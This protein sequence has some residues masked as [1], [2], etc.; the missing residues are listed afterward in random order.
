MA[1]GDHYQ[2]YKDRLYNGGFDRMG[3][4]QKDADEI[5]HYLDSGE[6]FMTDEFVNNVSDKI[7]RPLKKGSAYFYGEHF[8]YPGRIYLARDEYEDPMTYGIYGVNPRRHNKEYYQAAL[9]TTVAHEVGHYVDNYRYYKPVTEGN[10]KLVD[11]EDFNP[12]FSTY[13]LKY[14]RMR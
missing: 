2:A 10:G 13:Y 6:I 14:G 1:E 7:G 3:Y 8:P 5:K 12:S 4:S 11:H 9:P